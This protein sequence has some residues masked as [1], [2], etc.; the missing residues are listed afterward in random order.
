MSIDQFD[1]VIERRNTESVK[2]DGQKRQYH[3]NELTPFWIA[4]MDFAAEPCITQAIRSRAD[5][6]VYG[7]S[8]PPK[9]YRESI[10]SWFER[11]HHVCIK[12]EWLI[13]AQHAVTALA[14]AFRAVTRPGDACLVLTPA[15]DPFFQI[16]KG[17][18]REVLMLEMAEREQHYELDIAAMERC[19]AA[20]VRCLIF[21]N[22]HNPGGKAWKREELLAISKLCDRYDVTILSDDV[23]SDWV[24]APWGYTP[25][26][27]IPE[28]AG[29]T[30]M[31]TSPSK[32]FNVAGL[33]VSNLIIPG[34]A[35]RERIMREM[36]AMFVKGPN[37][38]GFVGTAAAYENA[39]PWVDEV[40]DYVY[41]NIVYAKELLLREA[42]GLH[43]FAP[44]STFMLWLDCREVEK[45]STAVC[46]C[47]ADKYGISVNS[48][49]L[50][51]KGGNGFIRM[52]AA[53]P[54][55]QMKTGMEALVRWYQDMQSKGTI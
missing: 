30:V 25:F 32:T 18:G 35:L 31:I 49:S 13:P 55:S 52:N 36:S 6:P 22:P 38:F 10:C 11:R 2:W 12:P 19:F 44:E 40:R 9:G 27:S 50:Y 37:L 33:C 17:A 43:L 7:Y 15:Y 46:E 20:G 26:I 3:S 48:G 21:C 16:I 5:H 42:P 24:Y 4:D 47:L 39:E 45:N 53:C 23:H 29:R 14:M 34:D 8:L 51:G 28:A 41:G 54:R 1:E